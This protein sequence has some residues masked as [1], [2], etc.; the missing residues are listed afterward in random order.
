MVTVNA[1]YEGKAEPILFHSRIQHRLVPLLLKNG[2]KPTTIPHTRRKC[3]NG[4]PL[5]PVIKC[6]G[7][8]ASQLV[9]TDPIFY[10]LKTSKKNVQNAGGAR[11]EYRPK[12]VQ[13]GDDS[14]HG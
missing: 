14:V 10:T 5:Q 3:H 7:F 8:E 13:P 6:Y 9:F 11:P 2:H 4:S 1:C 12:R